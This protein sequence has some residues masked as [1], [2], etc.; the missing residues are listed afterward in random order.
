M[1]RRPNAPTFRHRAANA[2]ALAGVLCLA[3]AS[4]AAQQPERYAL[5]GGDVAVYNLVGEV[6][7]EGGSGSEVVVEVARAGDDARQLQVRTG[8][9]GGRETLR[10]IYPGDRI[11]YREAGRWSQSTLRVRD[12]GTF[13]DGSGGGRRVTISGRG[14]GLDARAALTVRVPEGQRIRVHLG[15]GT[16]TVTNVDG[17]VAVDV[18]SA[19]IQTRNTRGRLLLDT[20]S[21][22]LRVRDAEGELDL[23][24]GSGSVELTNVRGPR[25]RVDAGSGS[26]T[27]DGIDVS[28][29]SV[30]LGSGRMRLSRVR[31]ENIDLDSGSGSVD[32]SLV[33]DVESLVVDAGSGSVTLRVPE[34]LGAQVD[35]ETG[36][37]GVESDL[38]IAVTRRSRSELRGTI[39]DGRGRIEIETGSGGVR[40]VKS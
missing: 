3:A 2:P 33:R 40:I 25:L 35:I 8:R 28:A 10:V 4:V 27:G 6:S 17:D 36:S 38:P 34:T 30:D 22:E 23:D 37:G 24:T 29:L 15:A 20:G 26:L 13:G 31:S 19:S 32:I 12:D 11:L 7:L 1:Q 16:A 9:I 21:G 18:A 39:G 14:D 5:R